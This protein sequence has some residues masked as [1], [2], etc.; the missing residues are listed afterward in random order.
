MI[1]K[2]IK[3]ISHS[4][5]L[6][7]FAAASILTACSEEIIIPVTDESAYEKAVQSYGYLRHAGTSDS[8]ISVTLHSAD[9]VRNIYL[10]VTKA[11]ADGMTVSVTIDTTLVQ[12]Y[13][14]AHSTRYEPFPLDLVQL[15]NGAKLSVNAWRMKSDDIAVTFTKNAARTSEG[16]SYLLPIKVA[17]DV[18]NINADARTLWYVVNVEKPAVNSAKA[19]GIISFCFVE[20]NNVNP[21]NVG[22]Y[23]ITNSANGDDGKPFFDICS[24]FAANLSYDADKGRPYIFFNENVTPILAQRDKYIKPLQDIGIK[25]TL[26]ILPNGAS[27][28]GFLNITPQGAKDLAQELKAICD[29]YG[30][31]GV[32]FDEE[33]ATYGINGLPGS[34]NVSY[35]RIVYEVK[36]AMPDKLVNIYYIG[37]STLNNAIV[38]GQPVGNFIDYGFGAYYGSWQANNITGVP[39]NRWGPYPVMLSNNQSTSGSGAPRPTTATVKA[40]T[41]QGYL[42]SIR[43]TYGVNLMYNIV[44][45]HGVGSS[46]LNNAASDLGAA[47]V[48]LTTGAINYSGYFTEF[49]KII[50]DGAEVIRDHEPYPKDWLK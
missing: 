19:S 4:I 14:I 3:K 17:D 44:G 12:A 35:G 46:E 2:Y 31:D 49:S 18:T 29:A 10:G 47:F 41:A 5:T 20:V 39:N 42:N 7:L 48:D 15:S 8:L 6:L 11:T 25:V 30:L 22:I 34:N 50:Y 28:L 13:N 16:T 21:L 45:Y 33:Y 27:G 26:A 38:E 36:Q 43:S 32:D 9:V 1:M 37:A 23:K 24:I 40:G